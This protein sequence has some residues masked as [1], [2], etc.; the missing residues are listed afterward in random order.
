MGKNDELREG[1]RYRA[2]CMWCERETLH[3]VEKIGHLRLEGHEQDALS[4]LC[5][6]HAQHGKKKAA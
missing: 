4:P 5:E 3:K 6:N 1:D 2:Y